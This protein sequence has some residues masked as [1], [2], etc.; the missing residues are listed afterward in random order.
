MVLND[1]T[2]CN[3]VVD[4]EYRKTGI[5]S[6][7]L[8]QVISKGARYLGSLKSNVRFYVNRGFKV[9]HVEYH[10]EFKENLYYMNYK[11]M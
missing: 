3:L 1:N 7:L 6:V 4:K 2:I 11:E 8:R 10:E 5:A 9:Y